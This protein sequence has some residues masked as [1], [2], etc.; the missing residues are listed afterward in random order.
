MLCVCAKRGKRM[1][2]GRVCRQ[3]QMTW[4]WGVEGS[5]CARSSMEGSDQN[6]SVRRLARLPAA[7]LWLGGCFPRLESLQKQEEAS[8]GARGERRSVREREGMG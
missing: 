8:E 4:R 6:E 3:R 5:K 2:T 7:E 1:G